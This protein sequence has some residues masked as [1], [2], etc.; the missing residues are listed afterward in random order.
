MQNSYWPGRKIGK[1]I[2]E[3]MFYNYGAKKRNDELVIGIDL[4]R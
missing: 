2:Y 3:R 4:N 1:I